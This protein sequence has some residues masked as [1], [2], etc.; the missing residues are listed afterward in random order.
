M[1]KPAG[2]VRAGRTRRPRS[3]ATAGVYPK[4]T[5]MP[6]GMLATGTANA[7]ALMQAVVLSGGKP[8]GGAT[9]PK[10]VSA[11]Y[12]VPGSQAIG[13]VG[14]TG[15]FTPAS[16]MDAF[17][18][19]ADNVTPQPAGSHGGQLACGTMSASSGPSGTVCVWATTTSMGM[20]GF[21][22][23]G[24]PEH[25]TGTKAGDDTVRLRGDAEVAKN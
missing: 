12:L 4:H 5:P 20:V 13:Y 8:D 15:N 6:G 1:L 25:V 9:S 22:G 2:R 16:V 11:D 10:F 18:K 7:T 21:F 19:I 23:G 14:F 3:P 24:Q 17:G